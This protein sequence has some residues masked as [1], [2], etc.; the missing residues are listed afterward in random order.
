M[1]YSY[2]PHQ[3]GT[4]EYM[5]RTLFNVICTMFFQAFVPSSFWVRA[6]TTIY[7]INCLPYVNF[8]WLS[9]QK[10]LFQSASNYSTFQIFCC[11]CCLHN[12]DRFVHNLQPHSNLYIFLGYVIN[13]L[14]YHYLGPTS[15]KI[16]ISRHVIFNESFFPYP[17]ISASKSISQLNEL[18]L[19]SSKFTK[20]LFDFFY[21]ESSITIY[22]SKIFSNTNTSPP[23]RIICPAMS[24]QSFKSP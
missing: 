18:L 3:I 9:P 19:S 11:A 21:F 1:S 2:T 15:N 7:T 16:T 17:M 6:S 20:T 12:L 13:Y 14:G 5:H 24:S 23:L 22:S 10:I 8:N 4:I